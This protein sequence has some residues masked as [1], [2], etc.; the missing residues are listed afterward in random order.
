[1]FNNWSLIRYSLYTDLPAADEG[2]VGTTVKEP[3]GKFEHKLF[4]SAL[5]EVLI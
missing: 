2:L 3:S 4:L 1:M 5:K